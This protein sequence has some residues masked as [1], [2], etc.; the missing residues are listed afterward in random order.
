MSYIIILIIL[1]IVLIILI[2]LIIFLLVCAYYD[3]NIK[4]QKSKIAKFLYNLPYGAIQYKIAIVT[5]DDRKESYQDYT[6]KINNLYFSKYKIDYHDFSNDNSFDDIPPWWRKVFFVNKIMN[7]NY[8]YVIWMDKDVAFLNHN[9]NLHSLLNYYSDAILLTS[10]DP[11]FDIYSKH[12]YFIN[13][14]GGYGKYH[15]NAGFFVLKN[16]SVGKELLQSWL[17]YYNPEQWCNV[18]TKSDCKLSHSFGNWKTTGYWSQDTFEQGALCNLSKNYYDQ[19]KIVIFPSYVFANVSN[20]DI[21]F[22]SHKMA[23]NNT[24]RLNFFRKIHKKMLMNNNDFL[25]SVK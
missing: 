24:S 4:K 17:S 8:D 6:K 1:T 25:Y 22:V 3:Y 12:K 10:N 14:F 11:V 5:Y 23:N 21:L 20:N 9:I 19:S 16:N 2:C 18:K 13:K 7:E 15:I